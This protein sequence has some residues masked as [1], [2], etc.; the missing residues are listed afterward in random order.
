MMQALA[1]ATT[2]AFARALLDIARRVPAGLVAWSGSDP[3]PR[4][5]VHRNNVRVSLVAALADTFPVVQPWARRR[6]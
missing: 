3:G 1:H 2:H 6:A 5:A 4:F